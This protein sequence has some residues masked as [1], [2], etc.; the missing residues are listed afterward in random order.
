LP[1]FELPDF[2]E[3]LGF[4]RPELGFELLPVEIPQR[5]YDGFAEL[6]DRFT[7]FLGLEKLAEDIK[8][9]GEELTF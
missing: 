8:G 9:N 2:P 1:E 3:L 5:I 7:S 4:E 6:R